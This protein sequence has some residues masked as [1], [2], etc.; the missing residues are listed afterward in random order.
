LQTV[1]EFLNQV[2]TAESLPKDCYSEALA[3][4]KHW[5][6]FS[7]KTF[8]PHEGF[9]TNIIQLLDNQEVYRKVVNIIKTLLVKS[10]HVKVME[11]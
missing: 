8:I 3:T 10:K 1:L 4:G 11:H 2:I 6:Y 9:I 7:S 5:C